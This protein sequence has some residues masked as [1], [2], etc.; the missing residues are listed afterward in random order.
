MPAGLLTGPRQ[1]ALGSRVLSPQAELG[2]IPWPEAGRKAR[3]TYLHGRRASG[4]P[5][6]R[7]PPDAP[8]PVWHRDRVPPIVQRNG[9]A[10]RDRHKVSDDIRERQ[11]TLLY[12]APEVRQRDVGLCAAELRHLSPIACD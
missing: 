8:I 6:N 1:A 5:L 7:R 3:G 12:S 2:P 4:K 10:S 9:T 11:Q